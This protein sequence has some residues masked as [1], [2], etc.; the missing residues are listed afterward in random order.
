M[1]E[2]DEIIYKLETEIELLK[3][4][5]TRLQG[6]LEKEDIDYQISANDADCEIVAETIEYFINENITQ[7]QVD[8]F[9]TLF[10]GRT[11]VYARRFIS[12]AGNVGYSPVC[13]NFWRHGVCPKVDKQKIKCYECSNHNWISL[14]RKVI[15]NHL[16]G[17]ASDCSDVIGV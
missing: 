14:S 4:E 13:S 9:I 16:M 11:D 1:N 8:L 3:K 17:Y 5:I 15:Y 10:H 2:K 12:K 6:L 7:E